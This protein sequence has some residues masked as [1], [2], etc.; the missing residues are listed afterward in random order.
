M[1]V[2]VTF[3]NG[4]ITETFSTVDTLIGGTGND[5]ISFTGILSNASVDLGGGTDVLTLGDL[6]NTVTIGGTE[7]ITGGAG[8]DTVTLSQPADHLDDGGPRD[9]LGL[10]TTLLHWT[11]APIP[12]RSAMSIH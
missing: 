4:N 5:T 3:G 2:I 7:T 8:D 9:G 11:T 12:A 1:S 10:A 6:G